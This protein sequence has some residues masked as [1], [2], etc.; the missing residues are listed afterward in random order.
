M[1]FKSMNPKF[2]PTGKDRR[3]VGQIDEYKTPREIYELIHRREWPYKTMPD[4]FHLRDQGYMAGLILTGGRNH[5]W[6]LARKRMFSVQNG[7]LI[8]KGLPI[9]KR[10]KKTIERYGK[11][12]TKRP[13]LAWPLKEGLF[14]DPRWNELIPFA[15]IVY[16]HLQQLEDPFS[17]LF[18]FSTVRGWQIVKY[19]TG[20]FPNWFRAQCE[21]IMGGLLKDSVKLAKYIGVLRPGQVA[22]YIGY[23]YREALKDQDEQ[24]RLWYK[25]HLRNDI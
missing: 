7:L 22:H 11:H 20:M 19:C 8:C 2:V 9:G 25:K 10:K 1:W 15:L 12:I 16:D 23:D 18:E 5:E 13:P 14:E 17:R 24:E 3:T 21:M 6:L 4:F